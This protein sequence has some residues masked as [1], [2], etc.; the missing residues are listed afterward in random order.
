VPFV[1]IA[2]ATAAAVAARGRTK[3]GL[4]ATAYTMVQDFYVGRLRDVH[5]LQFLVPDAADRRLDHDV[6]YG[7]LCVGVI[8]DRSREEY[9]RVM[10]ELARRGAEAILLG[11]TEI[12]LLVGPQ[13]SHVP[14]FDTTRLAAQA[15]VAL[16]LNGSG[17]NPVEHR[18][19]LGEVNTWYAE[20]GAGDPLVLL[21]PG[22]ANARAW[23]PNLEALGARFRCL[24]QSGADTGEP[25]TS[26]GQSPT[27][28]WSA[29][30]SSSR[31]RSPAHPSIWWAAAPERSS[32][33][34]W[35]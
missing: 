16:A 27:T 2:D 17:K 3:V 34:W 9:R 13:D 7:E 29:T 18:I 20:H 26:R 14:L 31:K 15:T 30:P 4:L 24:R 35:H 8:S 10:A 12:E 21:H 28:S 22:G 1:H 19:R 32:R 5:G 33:S 23:A 25:P 11:C 6:I